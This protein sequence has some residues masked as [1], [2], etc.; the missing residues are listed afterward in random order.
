MDLWLPPYEQMVAEVPIRQHQAQIEVAINRAIRDKVRKFYQN[1]Q[2]C[3]CGFRTRK[4][5]T[6]YNSKGDFICPQ[7]RENVLNVEYS[8]SDL[9]LQILYYQRLFN[10]EKWKQ[11]LDSDMKAQGILLLTSSTFLSA[12]F[13][14]TDKKETIK[15]LTDLEVNQNFYAASR[16]LVSRA[17]ARSN[18]NRVNLSSLF[19]PLS[20]YL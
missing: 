4:V 5:L 12:S 6:K 9:Y 17:M 13:S 16:R 10:Y 3:D 19:A 2:L 14:G 8:F 7:C 15:Q 20:A 1:W 18:Y 11:K